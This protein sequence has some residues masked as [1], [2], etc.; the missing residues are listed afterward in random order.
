MMTWVD[1]ETGLPLE[2]A[3]KIKQKIRMLED[4]NAR[5]REENE[6]LRI[7]I[8]ELRAFYEAR[9]SEINKRLDDLGLDLQVVRSRLEKSQST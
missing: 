3:E 5:L 6:K 7:T 9:L 8:Q 4:E 2:A 1:G